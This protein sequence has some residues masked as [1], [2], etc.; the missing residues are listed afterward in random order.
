VIFKHIGE[1]R[2]RKK[3]RDGKETEIEGEKRREA[4][5]RKEWKGR[6]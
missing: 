2:G 5:G 6:M 4:N 3:G 1:V